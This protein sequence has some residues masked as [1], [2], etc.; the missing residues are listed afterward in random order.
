MFVV[1]MVLAISGC[2]G[3]KFSQDIGALTK[4]APLS[5]QDLELFDEASGKV[6]D[7]Q[8]SLSPY[9]TRRSPRPI[10]P[11]EKEKKKK[12][13]K[14]NMYKKIRRKSLNQGA[15]SSPNLSRDSS[16]QDIPGSSSPI[17]SSGST[18]NMSISI[19]RSI[20]EITVYTSPVSSR[21][22][23]PRTSLIPK[24]PKIETDMIRDLS[25]HESEEDEC[26][27]DSSSSYTGNV[28]FYPT[29]NKN[30]PAGQQSIKVKRKSLFQLY[31]SKAA[32]KNEG[33]G[34][35]DSLS[36]SFSDSITQLRSHFSDPQIPSINNES[37]KSFPRKFDPLELYKYTIQ[38]LPAR[39]ALSL[40][41]HL[42]KGIKWE[43]L[44]E[45][46]LSSYSEKISNL[47][48]IP[49]WIKFSCLFH[50]VFLRFKT[51][52]V[53]RWSAYLP[54]SKDGSA[55]HT[56][57]AK[58]TL[59]PEKYER[60]S[61][62]LKLCSQ[63]WSRCEQFKFKKLLEENEVNLTYLDEL[64]LNF[65][66]DKEAEKYL[67]NRSDSPP[68][69]LF[70]ACERFIGHI[71]N[72]LKTL[73]PILHSIVLCYIEVWIG[74]AQAHYDLANQHEEIFTQ[75]KLIQLSSIVEVTKDP[76]CK[77][78]RDGYLD[79]IL[80]LLGIQ[81]NHFFAFESVI[82][83]PQPAKILRAY[84]KDGILLDS[85]NE[86]NM[87]LLSR[88]I[89]R[90]NSNEQLSK[91]SC[92]FHYAF[93]RFKTILIDKLVDCLPQN[94]SSFDESYSLRSYQL[95]AE[96]S[97]YSSSIQQEKVLISPRA[98]QE[99]KTG[100]YYQKSYQEKKDLLV[101]PRPQQDQEGKE[102][103]MMSKSRQEKRG[104]KLNLPGFLQEEKEEKDG[105]ASPKTNQAEKELLS[106]KSPQEKKVEL[107]SPRPP[108]QKRALT[109]ERFQKLSGGLKFC[110]Y[111]W[112]YCEFYKFE[113][114]IAE[115]NVHFWDDELGIDGLNLIHLINQEIKKYQAGPLSDEPPNFSY[116]AS[117]RF[118]TQIKELLKSPPEILPFIPE[119]I[120]IWIGF[121]QSQ[122]DLAGKYEEILDQVGEVNFTELGFDWS[123]MA[124]PC[125]LDKA[126]SRFLIDS[127]QSLQREQIA[128]RPSHSRKISLH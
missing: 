53:N 92:A 36:S 84:L 49:H 30:R 43:P 12:S 35:N 44:G 83:L 77:M 29:G 89:S 3:A 69:F 41:D 65:L 101:T 76:L 117:E 24:I 18:P 33:A 31:A 80:S 25:F 54:Q 37:H 104:Y 21:G 14:I 103:L 97:E 98:H 6:I 42:A 57:S 51:I 90:L 73:K 120:E 40:K 114:L 13:L 16:N 64:N 55:S 56:P 115:K 99:K 79:L 26:G 75:V 85:M 71:E 17:S 108:Q 113:K 11:K 5:V 58:K 19:I 46:Y 82:F 20:Q 118:L 4:S 61:G 124:P 72:L 74:F 126:S 8:E 93:I 22:S 9:L 102:G 48:S 106:S 88:E 27:S 34:G 122:Y 28:F 127:F 109:S 60:L 105:L 91:L 2:I 63:L 59:T 107:V 10:F 96:R 121:A 70:L 119:Y 128:T 38:S 62:G 1:T 67:R 111:L 39:Q 78:N 100:L 116:L 94:K 15:T 66:I 123:K 86:E 110:S 47:Q 95:E 50:G 112:S 68:K 23:T 125:I 45:K 87:H 7:G 32:K 52:L 81:I